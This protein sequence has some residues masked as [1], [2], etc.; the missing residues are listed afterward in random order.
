MDVEDLCR[1]LKPRLG[2]RIDQ[3]WWEYR[4]NPDSRRDIEGLLQSLAAKHLGRALGDEPILL[5]P[6][7]RDLAAGEYALGAVR[8]PGSTELPFGLRNAELIQ[9]A[10]IFGRTGS[11]KTN[12]GFLLLRELYRRDKPFLVFDWKRNYRDL[13]RVDP[14]TNMWVYTVGRSCVPFAFNPLQPPPGT[15]PTV[16]LKKLVEIMC[17]VYWLGEGVAYLLQQALDAAYRNAQAGAAP[18]LADVHTWLLNRK[19]KGRESQWMESTLRA[20]GTLCYGEIGRV[21]NAPRST[22]LDDLLTKS[23]IL[24]LDALTESDK[25]F[26]IEALLLWIHHYRLQQRERETTKHII[27]IEEA[28]H[29]LLRR[30]QSKETVM[31][32]V[33]REI[34]ELGEGLVLLDQHPSLI[35]IP[36]L[37]N[38]YCTIAM[39]LK[40]GR[41]IA[42][43]GDAMG[44]SEEQRGYLGR[45]DVGQGIVRL[46][47]RWHDPFLVAF[48]LLDV[49]KG[50][51]SDEDLRR[52][53][54]G[55]SGNSAPRRPLAEGLAEVREIR[56][57]D[58]GREEE[59]EELDEREQT[60]MSD[61][62]THPTNGVSE[63]FRRLGWSMDRGYTILDRLSA[64]GLLESARVPTPWGAVRF[65][66]PTQGG[67]LR[68]RRMGLEVPISRN[69]GA[70]HFYWK[71]RVAELLRE[72]GFDVRIEARVGHDRTVD[73]FAESSGFR[74][75]FEVETGMSGAVAKLRA[76]WESD[77]DVVVS[78]A[79]APLT[80]DRL[81]ASVV[82]EDFRTHRWTA[83]SARQLEAFVDQM[84]EGA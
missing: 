14:F 73:V 3:L 42:A 45:L 58:K 76:L 13:L 9:H 49:K 27:V 25:T 6:P 12:V 23:V 50:S 70:A 15:E 78:V 82:D 31:D 72:R 18:T 43:V 57:A 30:K 8:Y 36:A 40:H 56:P 1:K 4:L 29:V 66:Y 83:V 37:G 65:I 41:D 60:M 75:I 79:I 34:R 22:P 62:I 64:A 63:R 71:L 21:V 77:A 54:V 81:R 59:K 35:S 16:W 7:P 55:D 11:G 61:V 17:H 44:L 26:L 19:T 46:Q 67:A 48:P 39:N 53:F 32:V 28:H 2:N 68:M 74:A 47:G 69:E 80:A 51:V 10:A 52:R 5:V 38:T 84:R 33:F 20:I 24:E